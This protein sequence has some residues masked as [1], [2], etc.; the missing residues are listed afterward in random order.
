VTRA[1]K[2]VYPLAPGILQLMF[3]GRILTLN[4]VLRNALIFQFYMLTIQ[5]RL[6]LQLALEFLL[7]FFTILSLMTSASSALEY[8]QMVLSPKSHSSS[9][10][11]TAQL[12][13][14]HYTFI[15]RTQAA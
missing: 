12:S 10:F 6:A 11:Q 4:N 15:M 8:A 7:Q 5:R 2:L 9:A 3:L 1:Q 13:Q 14:P